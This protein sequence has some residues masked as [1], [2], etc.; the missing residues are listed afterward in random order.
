[1]FIMLRK[2]VSEYML[3]KIAPYAKKHAIFAVLGPLTIALE[4]LLEIQIPKLM[5]EIVDIGIKNSDISFILKTGGMMVLMALASLL[6]GGISAICSS[7]AAM[8]FGSELRKGIFNKLQNFSFSNVDKFSTASLITRITTDVNNTQH[9]YMM[10]IRMMVRSPVMLVS[11]TYMAF[12]INSSLVTV[13]ITAI[14]ILAIG[15]ILIAV[16][17]FPKFGI[18]MKKYDAINSTIQENLTAIRVV[19]AFVRSKYEKIKFKIA[20][21]GLRDTSITAEK[22]TILSNPLMQL[23]MYSCIIAILWFGGNMIVVGQMQTGELIGFVSYVTQILMSLM[24]ISMAFIMLTT[25]KASIHRINEVLS[26]ECDITDDNASEETTVTNGDILFENVCF[27]YDKNSE[28]DT[29][30][31]INFS[32]KSGETVGI[33]GGTGSAKTTLVQLIPR[34]YDTSSGTVYVGGK[35]VHEYKL[36]NLREAVSMVLQKNVLF[37]GTIKDNLK[38]G[39]QNATDEEI[40]KACKD[41]QAYE[42]IMSFPNGFDTILGQG[43][44]NVS[45]GQKQRLCIARALIKKP[46]IIILDD[47]TSAVDTATD[48]KIRDAFAMN[49]KDT[50]TIIIA[51]RITSICD[52]DK[53][54]VIDDGKISDI[55]NHKYL[56]ENNEIYRDVYNAQQKG[57]DEYASNA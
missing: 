11:A 42:F 2:A 55:G 37:S 8:G 16:H 10:I 1:M 4:V 9:A 57:V 7:I 43:G 14:P 21:Q 20:N 56:L 52:A 12:T 18:M 53:I 33:L 46:K 40:I 49:L 41:A 51:Q 30:K 39:N 22:I 32:I 19:K 45:G 3:K 6:F 34:L 36:E 5:S 23:V 25:S 13:F 26:E 17:S 31:N 27:K 54:I 24:M 28:I 35:D 15:M 29:L 44:V 47:S 50:T 38:W 48:S